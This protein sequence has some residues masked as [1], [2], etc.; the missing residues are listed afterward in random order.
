MYWPFAE[1][2]DLVLPHLCSPGM[3]ELGPPEIALWMDAM[4]SRKSCQAAAADPKLFLR[5]VDKHRSI[6]FFDYHT[7]N[8]HDLHPHLNAALL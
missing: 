4:Q 6:D 7:Y 2:F 3:R 8:A 5:A 1:R